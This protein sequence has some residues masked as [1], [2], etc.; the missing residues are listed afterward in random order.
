MENIQEIKTR[1]ID[2]VRDYVEG[3]HSKGVVL[4]MSGGKDSL[5]VAK[6]CTEALGSDK[7]YGIIMP[8]GAQKD[9]SD[10]IRQCE[11]LGIRYKIVNIEKMYN[12][13]VELTKEA[14]GT[15]ELSPVTTLNIAP[16]I[17]MS[18]LYS[19]AGTL[20]YLVANTSNLSEKIL[21]YSTKYGDS[22]GDFAP[23]GDLTKSEVCELGIALGLPEQ[24]VNKK[25]ADGL[26]GKTDEEVIGVPYE[27]VDEMARH[28][29]ATPNHEKILRMFMASAHKRNKISTFNSGKKN[30]FAEFEENYAKAQQQ[31]VAENGMQWL[32]T[33]KNK[34][35]K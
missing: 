22:A 32:T 34:K 10:A 4:G 24:D 18:M 14:L 2:Y 25:P 1:V 13:T 11:Y 7:V 20:G 19:A 6:I 3:A 9:L 29:T 35:K 27:E 15:D 33:V 21:G 8:N 28:G 31:D 12:A 30:F 26:T 5:I 17:R 23:I 16:R